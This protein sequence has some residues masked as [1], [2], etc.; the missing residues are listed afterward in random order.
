[1]WPF[2]TRSPLQRD[3]E[4]WQ[5]ETWRWLLE[6]LG[7]IPD[8]KLRPFVV[9][10]KDFFP[11][12]EAQGHD[13]ALHVFDRVRDLMDMGDWHCRLVPQ[14]EA[15]DAKVSEVAFLKFDDN[16]RSP[17]GT[18]GREGNEAVITYDPKLVDDPVSLV[19]TF[20]HELSHD[21]LS[22]R[23]EPPGGWDNHEFCTDL[24]VAYSGFGLFGAATA[25][26]YYS[27]AT[28][29]G[30]QKSGYLSQAE[31]T[32]ALAVFFALR[33]QSMEDGQAWLPSHLMNGVRRSMKYLS[34]K[35]ELLS[36]MRKVTS[37]VADYGKH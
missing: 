32:F 26:R 24:C 8:L 15:P 36:P 28:S 10:T 22:T 7:G 23:P 16:G 30:Y 2:A 35:P 18:Y 14:P 9:P 31:W 33:G 5:L 29:W 34:S 37:A 25:F 3:D 11:P 17:A 27:G 20:A 4:E 6:V 13:R 21:L 12:T 1:M 19:A